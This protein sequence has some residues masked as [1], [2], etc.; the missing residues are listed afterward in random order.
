MRNIK[1]TIR[2]I[3]TTLFG[4]PLRYIADTYE[5]IYNSTPKNPPVAKEG[6]SVVVISGGRNKDVL[7][8]FVTTVHTEL[9]D[10]NYEII[11]V[12]PPET[13]LSYI[14]KDVPIVHAP[15]RELS[16][17]TVP[18]GISKKKNFGA[19]YA[20]Y[21]K[22]VVS[23][24]YVHFLPG[25]KKGY[26]AFGDFTVCTNVVRNLDGSRHMDWV[27]WD[28][29]TVGI[30]LLPYTEEC[31]EY[32]VI[33]GNYFAV[34]RDFFLQ[35]PMNEKLRW[36][37]AEDIDWGLYVRNKTK[38]RVNPKSAVQYIKHKKGVIGPWLEGTRKLEAIF[39]KKII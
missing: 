20:K 30:G 16:L 34:K 5:K 35:N 33:G 37:E 26:D 14:A 2:K 6:W 1:A 15:W 4:K 32:Q 17:W 13:D 7:Q 24:D 9:R 3:F 22:L 19:R 36:G 18:F 10:T 28:Y 21:D 25:W 31:T 27:V 8:G 12:A 39:N 29:P 23:H 11:I 38:F